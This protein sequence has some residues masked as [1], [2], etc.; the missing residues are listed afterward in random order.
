MPSILRY[1]PQYV[2]LSGLTTS[3]IL[4]RDLWLPVFKP[5]W[6]HWLYFCHVTSQSS[7]RNSCGYMSESEPSLPGVF[8]FIRLAT[9]KTGPIQSV[10]DPCYSRPSSSSVPS[11]RPL[12]WL[13]MPL[14]G[15][16]S[17][18]MT[19]LLIYRKFEFL[20]WSTVPFWATLMLHFCLGFECFV[21]C[22]LPLVI[23]WSRNEFSLLIDN[24][25][26]TLVKSSKFLG[27]YVDEHMTWNE[28]INNISIKTAKSIGVIS[29]IAYLLPK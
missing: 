14:Q 7:L 22:Y 25:P 20:C 16:D 29:R 12:D 3:Q 28:H 23:C 27:V 1:V 10:V 13:L 8:A 19:C 4:N 24:T 26:L 15:C 6:C 21:Y 9:H 5:D 2:G 11:T 17:C 18:P